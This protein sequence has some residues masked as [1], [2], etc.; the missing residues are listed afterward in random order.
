M[1]ITFNAFTVNLQQIAH[2]VI[3][4]NLRL[5]KIDSTTMIPGEK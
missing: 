1:E 2:R 5:N 4:P 3:L